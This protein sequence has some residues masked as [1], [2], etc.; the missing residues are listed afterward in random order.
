[1]KNGTKDAMRLGRPKFIG[2]RKLP[3]VAI[4]RKYSAMECLQPNA[5]IKSKKYK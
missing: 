2:A 5:K 4:K 3:H 1:M